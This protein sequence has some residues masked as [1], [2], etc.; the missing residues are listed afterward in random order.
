MDLKKHLQDRNLKWN[1]DGIAKY[2]VTNP[3]VIHQIIDFCLDDEVQV[4]QNA[5]AVLGKIIDLDKHILDPYV[6]EMVEL[7]GQAHDAVD[8]GILRVFQWAIITEEIEGELFEFVVSALKSLEAPIAIKVFGMTTGRRICEKYPE[9][10]NE[11]I[12]LIELIIEEKPSAGLLSRGKKELKLL[13]K[14]QPY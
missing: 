3:K 6:T 11:M 14:L 4:Q 12:P 7:L 9:L 5:G 10:A 1:W 13:T 2:C 8:R